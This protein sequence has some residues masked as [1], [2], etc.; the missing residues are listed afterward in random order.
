VVEELNSPN[1][2]DRLSKEIKNA[3]INLDKNNSDNKFSILEYEDLKTKILTLKQSSHT[4]GLTSEQSNAIEAK[5]DHLTDMAKIL[6]KFDW[7]SLFVGTII[8][9]VIQLNVTQDNAN[10]LWTLIRQIFK[11]FLLQ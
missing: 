10:S 3:G 8:S 6:N 4:I 5:L 2:W 11:N 9:V 1:K 7:K